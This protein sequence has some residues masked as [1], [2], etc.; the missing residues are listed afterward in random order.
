LNSLPSSSILVFLAVSAVAA[1]PAQGQQCPQPVPAPAVATAGTPDPDEELIVIESEGA[2]V[3]RQGDARLL[4][5]VHVRQ[6]DRT[7]SAR[8]ASY[9]ATSRS[10]RVEGDVE[11]LDPTLR[12]AG[13]S[14]DWSSDVG[15]RFTETEFELP[16]RPARGAADELRLSPEGNLGLTNPVFTTC[17]VGNDDW[18]LK[19]SSIAID[20]EREQGTGRDVRLELKGVPLLYLPYITFPA[21]PSRKSGFLFPSVGTSSRSGFELGVPYYFN[22]APN[23]DAIFEPALLTRRG[24]RFGG[25]FRYLT[26]RSRGRLE[27]SWLPSDRIAD[28][29]RSYGKLEHLT[30]FSSSLRLSGSLE[31]AS[32]SEYFEDFARGQQGTSITYLERRVL[33]EWLGRGWRAEGLLQNFQTIDRTI[34]P[35]DRPYTRVPRLALSGD[36]PVG[37]GG[38]EAGVSGELVYFQRDEG[39]VGARLDLEPRITWPVRKPGYFLEPYAGFRYTAYQLDETGPGI[40]DSASRAAPILSLDAGLVFDR[41]AGRGDRLL[42][43][44]EP[45][46]LYTWIPYRQQD[47]LPVFDTGLPELDMIG[48]FR[49]NRFVGG[50]RLADA[51]Q[52]AV[53]VTTRLVEAASGRQY[54]AATIGQQLYFERPRVALPGETPET[55]DYSDIIGELELSAYKNWSAGLAMQW[56]PNA[57]NTVL[58]QAR[59]QYRPRPDSVVNLG[60]RYREGRVEQWDG[61]ASWPVAREWRLYARYV[62]SVRDGQAVDSFLGIEYAACCWRLRLVASRYVSSRTGEQDTAVALQLE[63][64]GLSSVGTTADTFLERGIRGYSGASS[65]LP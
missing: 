14:G 18:L 10:F 46:V 65:P 29:S 11:Y 44:L 55:R 54:L 7:L 27:G 63:L 36:W 56:D 37:R 28:R 38:P 21:G 58:G 35:L 20:R 30:D 16:T 45:R 53:G 22:L 42:H 32:D 59:V 3:T 49:R 8:N 43:T 23:Y 13:E 48:L 6:G 47:D 64:N 61:S 60:Y 4:G 57:S 52:L 9:D 51:N 25:Q 34:D 50:D 39:T 41:S 40:D 2:E 31:N 17:P 5:K 15:G 24:F 26:E 33:V 19:A 1:T 62:Y 12:I